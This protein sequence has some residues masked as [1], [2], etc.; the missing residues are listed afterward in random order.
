MQ[1]EIILVCSKA[2][3]YTALN[4]IQHSAHSIS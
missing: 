3:S 4:I 1:I 2:V